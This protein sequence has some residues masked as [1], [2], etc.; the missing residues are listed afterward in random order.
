MEKKKRRSPRIVASRD[1]KDI[2]LVLDRSGY[3]AMRMLAFEHELSMQ[4]VYR[5]FALE[6]V[7]RSASIIS[8]FEKLSKFKKKQEIDKYLG[9]SEKEE[10]DTINALYDYMESDKTKEDNGEDD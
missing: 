3:I 4:D 5:G 2:H 8:L 7:N 9:I 1:K 10:L 6:C